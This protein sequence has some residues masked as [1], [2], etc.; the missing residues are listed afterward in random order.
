[1]IA[2]TSAITFFLIATV[3]FAENDSSHLLRGK[4]KS[5]QAPASRS[6]QEQVL[7]AAQLI[8]AN[9]E[10]RC[11]EHVPYDGS[12][13]C[14]FRTVLPGELT[15]TGNILRDCLRSNAMNTNYCVA[16]EVYNAKFDDVPV[17]EPQPKPKPDGTPPINGGTG[18]P[19]LVTELRADGCPK[20]TQL[21]GMTCSEY[22]PAGVF[23]AS[24]IYGDLKCVCTLQANF[25]VQEAW[26]CSIRD[27]PDDGIVVLPVQPPITNV[28]F[29][30]NTGTVQSPVSAPVS[31]PVAVALP[32]IINL[33]YC[34]PYLTQESIEGQSCTM[35]QRC[36]YYR[37]E[38]GV[39][40][41]A[42]SCD[43]NSDR[44]FQCRPSLDPRF[45]P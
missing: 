23:S 40:V 12:I 8:L 30:V 26:D 2:S 32:V 36:L 11:E 38:N 7:P 13:V 45:V 6:L 18:Q 15:N 25:A 31:P 29:D 34:I 44:V 28:D 21:T 4:T 39:N 22:V 24:C 33:P 19:P 1:M 20:R 35:H 41:G 14:A 9:G 43:C 27:G 42:N 16:I 3:A 17:T 10:M 37:Q 5:E